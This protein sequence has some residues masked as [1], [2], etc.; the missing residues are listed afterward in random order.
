MYHSKCGI[1]SESCKASFNLLELEETLSTI[2]V[3]VCLWYVDEATD[4]ALENNILKTILQARATKTIRIQNST[5]SITKWNVLFN[6]LL[7]FYYF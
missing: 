1:I 3:N 2:L 6:I 5:L 7:A 4:L